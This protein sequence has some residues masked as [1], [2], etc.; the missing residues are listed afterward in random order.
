M[1]QQ[2]EALS[3]ASRQETQSPVIPSLSSFQGSQYP[4][5]ALE[6]THTHIHIKKE[7]N[8]KD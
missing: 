4:L 5:L 6:G 2:S 1:T 3:A 7:G 8:R